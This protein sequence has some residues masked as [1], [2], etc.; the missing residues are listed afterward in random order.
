MISARCLE[1]RR[2]GHRMSYNAWV[3]NLRQRTALG[4][5]TFPMSITTETALSRAEA[6]DLCIMATPRVARLALPQALK[7]PRHEAHVAIQLRQGR[8]KAS[9]AYLERMSLNY[10][11]RPQVRSRR[12]VCRALL[13]P[14]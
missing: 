9:E 12:V 14:T 2:T 11:T 8:V 4:L 10:P 7:G 13:G 5:L 1:L 6:A 3:R